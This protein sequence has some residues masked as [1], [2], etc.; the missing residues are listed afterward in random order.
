MTVLPTAAPL[1]VATPIRTP[2]DGDPVGG[3]LG[4]QFVDP[5]DEAGDERRR[6]AA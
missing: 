3:D 5:P 1:G 6:W 4:G 2:G